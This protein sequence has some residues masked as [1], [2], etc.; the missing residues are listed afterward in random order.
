MLSLKK[1]AMKKKAPPHTCNE[2]FP[3]LQNNVF[4]TRY[5][6]G[7]VMLS[8]AGR[9]RALPSSLPAELNPAP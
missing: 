1:Y 8:G 6:F 2:A 9:S 7:H 3:Y 5:A 4:G